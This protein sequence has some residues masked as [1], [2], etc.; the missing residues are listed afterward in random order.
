LGVSADFRS[1]I[2]DLG[3]I[4]GTYGI[5][6]IVYYSYLSTPGGEP[7]PTSRTY[8]L[9]TS[10]MIG[11]PYYFDSFFT[12]EKVFDISDIENIEAIDVRFF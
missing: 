11:N 5:A 4:K 3:A 12:Q 9:D 7:K 8:I 10:D 2:S 6:I 1:W